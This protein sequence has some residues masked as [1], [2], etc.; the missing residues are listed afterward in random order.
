VFSDPATSLATCAAS[1]K[2]AGANII[3]ALT[4]VG[5]NVDVALAAN[6]ALA[7]V[8][9]IIGGHSHSLFYTGTPPA[10]LVKPMTVA[11]TTPVFGAYPRP[12]ANG[13]KSIPVT[14]ALWGSR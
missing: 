10:L 11:E 6:P 2:A 4:H 5:A 7:D 12:V 9:L 3:I 13:A 14:S 8:D 1:A